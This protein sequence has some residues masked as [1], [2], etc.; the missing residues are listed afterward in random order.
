MF[1]LVDSVSGPAG[2]MLKSLKDFSSGLE[3]GG[4]GLSGASDDLGKFADETQAAIEA[5]KEIAQAI[6]AVAQ[7]AIEYG[8]FVVGA[9]E[10]KK[11]T[12]AALDIIEGT[13]QAANDTYATLETMANNAGTPT[14]QVVDL[15]KQLRAAGFA[16]KDAEA[17]IAAGLDESAVFGQ[18]AGQGLDQA[19]THMKELGKVDPKS[20]KQALKSANIPLDENKRMHAD[21]NLVRDVVVFPDPKSPEF[22]ELMTRLPALPTALSKQILKTAG[23]TEGLEAK[24]L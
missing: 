17:I 9:E 13:D 12:I 6:E 10:F 3:E 7:K 21:D 11:Q 14:A 8:K 20:L 23:Y 15:Y 16:A 1:K 4:E 24:K 2:K 18:A 5:A 19:I 22:T